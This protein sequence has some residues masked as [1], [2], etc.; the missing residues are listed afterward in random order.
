MN[1]EKSKLFDKCKNF[2][3]KYSKDAIKGYSEVKKLPPEEQM[4]I[5]K[6]IFSTKDEKLMKKIKT[7]QLRELMRDL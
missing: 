2:C 5:Y 4:E 1:S 6:E 3:K 7:I